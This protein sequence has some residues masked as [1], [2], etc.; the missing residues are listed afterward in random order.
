MI[1]IFKIVIFLLY[2]RIWTNTQRKEMFTLENIYFTDCILRNMHNY[3][4]LIHLDPDEYVSSK[5]DIAH[6]ANLFLKK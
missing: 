1:R 4:F 2:F 3:R 5:R 6:L